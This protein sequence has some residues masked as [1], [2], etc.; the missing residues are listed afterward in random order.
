MSKKTIAN[1]IY[2]SSKIWTLYAITA[3]II[4][5]LASATLYMLGFATIDILVCVGISIGITT[6]ITW[7]FWAVWSIGSMAYMFL[8]ANEDF[9]VIREQIKEARDEIRQ[10]D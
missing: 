4:F 8:T 6:M 5:V 2:K 7:W 1:W 9:Q 10:L 3:P